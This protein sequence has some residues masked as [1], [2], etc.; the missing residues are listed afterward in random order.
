MITNVELEFNI[1]SGF[2]FKLNSGDS[3]TIYCSDRKKNLINGLIHE[4]LEATII[5]AIECISP[6]NLG[7]ETLHNEECV[8]TASHLVTVVSMPYYGYQKKHEEFYESFFKG[9]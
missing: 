2:K 1:G 8:T 5:R 7:N 4:I 6:K 3:I 9:E